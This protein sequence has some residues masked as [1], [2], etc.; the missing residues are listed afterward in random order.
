[1]L[2]SPPLN[3]QFSSSVG[4]DRQD[5]NVDLSGAG[6]RLRAEAMHAEGRVTLP[7]LRLESGDARLTAHGESSSTAS[8]LYGRRR[9]AAL[10]PEPLRQTA[11]GADQCPPEGQKGDSAPQ[12]VADA[13]FVLQDSRL[14]GQPV[15]GEGRLAI[16][17]PRIPRLDIRL[18]AGA[19]RLT[20][21]GAFGQAGD[22]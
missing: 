17:W 9:I 16:A 7:Q 6:F 3:G 13:S 20:A 8:A 10:R 4:G 12:P 1:M 11:G 2:R 14:A 22:R 15:S 19:N 21:Q 18:A 5:L